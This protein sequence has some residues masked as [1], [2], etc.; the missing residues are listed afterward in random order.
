[1]VAAEGDGQLLAKLISL[2]G[3]QLVLDGRYVGFHRVLHEDVH[4]I[5]QGAVSR[6]CFFRVSKIPDQQQ[7]VLD[8]A[9]IFGRVLLL[10]PVLDLLEGE[11]GHKDVP[12]VE[13]EV[14]F[15]SR[16]P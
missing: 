9:I 4:D 6:L 10:G 8:L 3:E 2:E 11:L 14:F 15:L 7:A 5:V 13:I 12:V 16:H 1:M